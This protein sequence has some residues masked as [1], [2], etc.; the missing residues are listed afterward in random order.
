MEGNRCH[1]NVACLWDQRK[2]RSK[3]KGIA[4]GY[5]LNEDGMWRWHSWGL[6][7]TH[8]LETTVAMLR[9]FGIPMN[10][11]DADAFAAGFLSETETEFNAKL[12]QLK[13]LLLVPRFL[14]PKVQWLKIPRLFGLMFQKARRPKNQTHLFPRSQHNLSD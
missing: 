9:Y 11:E 5:A 7:A 10:A 12:E 13:H 2:K 1:E 4:T 3:L 8:I 6:T 14:A